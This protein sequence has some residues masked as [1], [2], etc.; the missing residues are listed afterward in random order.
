MVASLAFNTHI[1]RTISFQN[2]MAYV[3]AAYDTRR[4]NI[5]FYTY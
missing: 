3:I 2:A 1:V 4:I 5:I